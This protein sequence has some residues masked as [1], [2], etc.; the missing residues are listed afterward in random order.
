MVSSEE[1]DGREWSEGKR[2]DASIAPEF[3]AVQAP[4][5]SRSL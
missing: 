2:V 1:S 5:Q 3:R 4:S